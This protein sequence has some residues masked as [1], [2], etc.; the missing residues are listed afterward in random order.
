[1]IFSESWLREWVNTKLD[2][3]DLMDELTMAGL[4]AEGSD[5]VARE[6]SGII[7]GEVESVESHPN[8]DKL[9]VCKVNDGA[10]SYQVVCGATNVRQGIKVPFANI[11]AEIHTGEDKPFQIKSAKLRGIES[12]GMICSSEELGLEEKSEGI[13]VLPNE[14]PLGVDVRNYL[15]LND[16]SIELTLTP[17]RGDCLGILGLAREV[18]VISGHPVTEPEIPPVASTINDELPIR[19]SAKDG[20]PRYLGRIIRNVNLKSESPLWMQEKLRRSGLRSID[21]IVDVTNFVLMELGQP[22]H[23]FD[24]SKLKGHINVRMAKKNEKLIL[25]D[26]KEVDLSPEIMLIADKNK[27]VAMAGIMGGLETSVTDSTKDVF[28][29]CAFFSPLTVAGKA[30]RYGMQTDAS[31][32]YERGVDYNLQHKAMERATLLLLEIVGGEAGPITEAVGNLPKPVQVEL[33]IGTVSR[34]LGVGVARKEIID[35][36]SKL[37]FVISSKNKDSVMVDVPSFRFDVTLEADLIEEIARIYGYNK[38]PSTTRFG[39]RDFVSRSEALVPLERIRHQLVGLGYQE[40]ITYSF[41]DP[42]L[43]ELVCEENIQTVSLE[44]PISEEMSVMR[45]SLLPGLLQTAQYNANRQQYRIRLFETGMV[46]TGK[47]GDYEQI[48]RIAGLISGNRYPQNW[49]NEKDTAD[50]Y[51]LK[52]D[53]ESILNL[54]GHKQHFRYQ[55][56]EFGCFHPGQCARIESREGDLLGHA[57]ALHPAIARKLELDTEAFLFELD[58]EAVQKGELSRA[59]LLSRY[60]EVNRDLAFVIDDSIVAEEI[61]ALVRDNAGEYLTSLRIFDVYQ[62]DA[63][64]KGKKSVALGLTWQ[65]PSRTLSDDE[66][67]NIIGRCVSVLQE[68][69]NANLRN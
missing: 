8:A 5:P 23:A 45:A 3:Q 34:T 2:T 24:Y 60:P 68:Q 65:H 1:M 42:E 52:G 13:M 15:Q 47:A 19:I 6:F 9:S 32:R 40:V 39:G 57:G 27:P 11:G 17:N 26:G 35:I 44:N 30:R 37:G 4:E 43:S 31:H 58:L 49:N 36:L 25:L 55:A 7:V 61:L 12:K 56:V 41:I 22:M 18:G 59:G 50:F 28:L 54:G 20:C 53:V 10:K 46:F 66:I 38:V 51:D 21:P 33:N 63:I 29:E 62:G 14:A 48:D 64:Q 16:T 67:S 69:F